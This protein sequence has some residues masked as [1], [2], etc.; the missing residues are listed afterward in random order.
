MIEK[1]DSTLNNKTSLANDKTVTL[2]NHF[3]AFTTSNNEFIEITEYQ[4]INDNV[5]IGNNPQKSH[6]GVKRRPSIAQN[7]KNVPGDRVYAI[8]TKYGKKIG[9]V[10][11][12]QIKRFRRNIFN[13]LKE[14]R[15][16][17][18]K[19]FSQA[20]VWHPDHVTELTL[21]EDKPDI[22]KLYIVL[23]T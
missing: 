20:K 21:L 12:S 13:N 17:N 8:K 7:I 22:V 18:L 15:N 14:N 10:G 4:D 16:A 11:N 3:N 2:K 5:T 23:M 19:Y 6:Q 1:K 9:I